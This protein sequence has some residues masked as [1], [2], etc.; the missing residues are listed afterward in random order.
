M[1]VKTKSKSPILAIALSQQPNE[2]TQYLSRDALSEFVRSEDGQKAQKKIWKE[3]TE[4]L[5]AI[6]PGIMGQV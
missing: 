1:I 2:L 3:L 5:E 4:K 6:E